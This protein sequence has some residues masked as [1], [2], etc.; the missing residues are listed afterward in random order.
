MAV[1]VLEEAIERAA[2]AEAA[3]PIAYLS[4]VLENWRLEGLK[5]L[6]DVMAAQY[7]HDH[8]AGK[9]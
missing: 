3:N 5:T 8:A 9:L 7:E 4:T 6:N 1:D 2:R